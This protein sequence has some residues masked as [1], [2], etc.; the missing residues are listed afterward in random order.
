MSKQTEGRVVLYRVLTVLIS[1]GI[2]IAWGW[3][4]FY[5]FPPGDLGFVVGLLI[6]T[7]WMIAV[8]EY[9]GETPVSSVIQ[10]QKE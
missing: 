9:Y 4:S 2:I 10:K 8:V 3:I 7:I 5:V 6:W 1:I